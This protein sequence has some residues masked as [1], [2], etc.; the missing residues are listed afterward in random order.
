MESAGKTGQRD[1]TKEQLHD[2]VGKATYAA[3][4]YED[5]NKWN[6]LKKNR[7]CMGFYAKLC[8]NLT[9]Q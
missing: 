9:S 8:M 4:K 6:K 1:D 2:K 7:I 5:E 3:T